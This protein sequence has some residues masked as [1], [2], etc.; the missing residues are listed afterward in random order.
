MT[1]KCPDRLSSAQ[2]E[3]IACVTAARR[4]KPWSAARQDC[5]LAL[6][7]LNYSKTPPRQGRPAV[8]TA[9]RVADEELPIIA[10]TGWG[11]I[12]IAV[13]A[14]Q[15]GAADSSRSP[16]RT[17]TGLLT[18]LR[19]Q[20][21]LRAAQGR[22]EK[23]SAETTAA[24]GRGRQ[25][26]DLPVTVDGA[27]A[28]PR[29]T[30]GASPMPILITARTA[31]ARAWLAATFIGIRRLR[32]GPSSASTWS[33][34]EALSES[35]NVPPHPGAFTEARTERIGRVEL[36]DRAPCSWTRSPTC[37]GAAGEDP[38]PA[39]RAALREAGQ[40]AHPPSQHP[41]HF[42]T[43]A[44]LDSLLRSGFRQDLLYRLNGVTLHIPALR[45]R[46]ADIRPL[47]ESF[48]DQARQQLQQLARARLFRQSAQR[49]LDSY[50][51]PGNIRELQHVVETIGTACATGEISATDLQ[52]ARPAVP[53]RKR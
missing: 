22:E 14:M 28:V 16:G 4:N 9:L 39:R 51:W 1:M 6:V 19:T 32:R 20:M 34:P 33:L 52:L 24:R 37:A 31:R 36:A 47:A 11:T 13:E 17:T 10:M 29:Q 38:A 43:N 5:Q 44:D 2:E 46:Q 7:D 27:G 15:R 3:G 42:S 12:G 30:G 18:T 41:F 23:L 25:Q 45:E 21:K 40:L 48:L 8:I 50:A 35:E 53:L 49:A 26:A